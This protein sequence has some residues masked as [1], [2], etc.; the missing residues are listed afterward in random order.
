ME[1]MHWI[2][3][4]I[5]ERERVGSVGLVAGARWEERTGSVQLA[6]NSETVVK[7]HERAAR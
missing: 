1:V 7:Q 6:S 3:A 4:M 5:N 2:S